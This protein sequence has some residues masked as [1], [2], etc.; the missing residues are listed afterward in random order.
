MSRPAAASRGRVL[1]VL[2]LLAGLTAFVHVP[3]WL[4]TTGTSALQGVVTVESSGTQVAPAGLA[5]AVVLLAAGAAAGLVGRGGRWVVG[6]VVA[7]AG[8]LV[9]V[10][11]AV[12]LGGP[13]RAVAPAVVSATGVGAL[14][15]PVH[16]APWPWVALV[17]G[18]L[19]VVAAGWFVRVA[20]TWHAP[21]R[22]YDTVATGTDRTS[23]SG[24]GTGSGAGT[25]TVAGPVDDERAA[26][27][28]LSRGDD[29]S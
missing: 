19:G 1:L 22:R 6:A 13:E 24:S 27:D 29:P 20:G 7:A 3:T 14:A 2:V 12:V 10:T 25:G 9:V 17:A 28:A 15:G 26:W 11:A 4:T 8:S 18:A 23:G 5:A 21:T 16:V